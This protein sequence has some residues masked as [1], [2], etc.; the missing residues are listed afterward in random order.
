M[1]PPPELQQ[2]AS[3]FP[4]HLSVTLNDKLRWYLLYFM[5]RARVMN[6]Y[7]KKEEG[8]VKSFSLPA[9]VVDR[10]IGHTVIMRE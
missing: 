10:L 7:G 9:L 2:A 6:V 5:M 4:L 8:K 3:C 1:G